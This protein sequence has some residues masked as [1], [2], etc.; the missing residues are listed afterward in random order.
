MKLSVIGSN[1]I[2]DEKLIDS[3]LTKWKLN[4]T[5]SVLG[6]GGKGVASLVKQWCLK[7]KINHVEFLPYF[8]LDNTVDF[9]NKYFFIRNKQLVDNADSVLFI[10]NGDCKD[11]EYAIKYCQKLHKDYTVVKIPK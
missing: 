6:G 3:V 8:L 7:N 10:Y 11:V 9:S 5:S 4:T 1:T 2:T